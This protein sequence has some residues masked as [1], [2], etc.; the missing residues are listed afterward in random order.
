MSAPETRAPAA[1]PPVEALH[2]RRRRLAMRHAQLISFYVDLATGEVT[3]DDDQPYPR[4]SGFCDIAAMVH[5]DFHPA[6]TAAW[7]E[8]VATGEPAF[9]E[10]ITHGPDGMGWSACS[11]EAVRGEDGCIVGLLGARQDISR[12][13]AVE[14]ELVEQSRRAEAASQAKSEFL[15]NMS[16]EIRTPLNGILTMAQI[17]AQGELSSAQRDLLGVVRQSGHDLLHLL[18]DILDFSKIEAGKLELEETEFDP[19][20]VLE[21]TLAGFAAVAEKKDLQLWLN[22]APSARGLRRGDPARLRQIV[23]NFVSNALKFTEDGGVRIDI[24]GLGED[25]HEGL[26]LAVRDTGPGV[27]ADKMALLFQKFSQVDASTTRRY[28]GSGLGLA[29]CQELA[30][31]MQGRVWAESVEG[32]GSTFFA[33]LRLPY[34]RDIVAEADGAAELEHFGGPPRPLRL[35]AAEDNTTNQLVLTTVMGVFGFDLTLVGDGAQAVAAWREQNYDA[36]LMDVQMP[37]MDGVQATRAIRAEEAASG[38]PRTP[39]VALS[40]NAF[41]HQVSEYLTAGM[42]T[43]V[44]KPIELSALRTALDYVLASPEALALARAG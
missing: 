36:I 42:D 19:E 12:R 1:S 38:R 23:A 33:E 13:K 39:I 11:F 25:G 8:H 32:Q 15:A 44:A 22:L 6:M 24:V 41:H 3:V 30:G 29:I 4:P 43:H 5:P 37:V 9:L 28:G 35:L 7:A 40:A 34:L 20:T 17:M 2:Q 27:A 31:L 10:A 16:H 14:L 21:N 26:Q 18:N